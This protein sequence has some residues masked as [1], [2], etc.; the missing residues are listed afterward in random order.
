MISADEESGYLDLLLAH[1]ISRTR[2]LL[3]RLAALIVGAALIAVVV[4]AGQLAVR[5][6]AQLDSISVANFAAQAVHLTLLAIFFG[7]V[8]VAIGAATGRSRATVFGATAGLGVLGYA[9]N[10]FA[11]QIGVE[12]L[13]YLTPMHY[14][15]GGEPMENGVQV[16]D[17]V[18]LVLLT[19]LVTAAGAQLFNR[20]DIAR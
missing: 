3:E 10:G 6:S 14:Y 4:L 5:G 19:V 7:A 12:W 11:P 1:P 16:F 9:V 20:R 15:I 17:A 18:I 2:L 13:R 8:A